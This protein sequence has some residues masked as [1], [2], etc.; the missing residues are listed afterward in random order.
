MKQ[1]MPELGYCGTERK[2]KWH[3]IGLIPVAARSR[4]WMCDFEFSRGLGCL[5]LVSVVCVVR[6]RSLRP[7]DQSCREVLL[8]VE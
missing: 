8:N 1:P 5:S 2:G 3:R 4:A 7:A 6:W